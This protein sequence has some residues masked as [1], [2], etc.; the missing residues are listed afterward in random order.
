MENGVGALRVLVQ[1]LNRL[2]CRQNQ[3]FNTA[4]PCLLLHFVHYRQGTH[5]CANNQPLTIPRYLL[6][7]RQRRMPKRLAVLLGRLFLSL[8]DLSVINHQ[9]I[10]VRCPIDADAAKCKVPQVSWSTPKLATQCQFLPLFSTR[11]RSRLKV[12]VFFASAHCFLP[13]GATIWNPSFSNMDTVP[14]YSA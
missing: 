4:P 6:F 11:S 3:Q 8:L 12:T 1:Y 5:T 14:R 13:S 10:G 2:S 7:D 9:I